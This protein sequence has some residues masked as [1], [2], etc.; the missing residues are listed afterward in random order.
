MGGWDEEAWTARLEEARCLRK[1]GDEGGFLRQALAA[2]NQRPQRAEPL[3]DL[4]RFYRE[5]GMNDASALFAEAGLAIPRPEQD[6]LFLEDFVYT[7]GLREE[8]SIAANYSRDPVRKDRGYAACNWL[9][10]NRRI[11][12]A[13]REL[14]RSNLFFYVQPANTMMP[15]FAARPV[16]FSPPDGYRASNPSVARWGEQ[17]VLLQRT[18]NYTLTEDGQYQTSSEVSVHTRNF[19][20]HLTDELDIQSAAEIFPPA[21]M[22]EPSYNL[23][24]GFEDLRLFAWR[25]DLWGCA[26]VRE[27][28]PEGWCEQVI[29]RIDARGP[30][31]CRLTDWRVL[32]P[33]GPRL[34]EKNWMPRV[35]GDRLQFICRCDPTQVLDDHA[36][37]T[38]EIAPAIAAERFSGGSQ[39]IEFDR[40][41]LALVHEAM[42]RPPTKQRFYQ[43][44]FVWFDENNRLRCVSH[45]FFFH[46]K[47]VEFA[48]GLTWHPDGKR[49]LISFGVGDAEAWIATVDAAEVQG[50]LEDVER[51]PSA[52]S[53]PR[54]TPSPP[55]TSG[56]VT[57]NTGAQPVQPV[58]NLG[59]LGTESFIDQ[60][61]L[62]PARKLYSQINIPPRV[63][64]AILAKQKEKVLPLYLECI[65]SLDYPK[66]SIV[67][68]IRTNNNTD[69]TEEL[70]RE[71]IEPI[72]HLYAGVEFDSS[73]V[74]E[75]VQKYSVHEWN[76][77]RFRVLANIR[78]ISLS[79][80]LEHN[81]DFYFISDV[82]NFFHPCTLRELVA[83]NLPIVAP[84]LRSISANNYFS[85]LHAE[86]DENGYFSACDQYYWIMHRYVRGVFEVP[87]VHCTYAIRSDVIP[88]LSYIDQT[89][90]Y[91]YVVFSHLARA[92]G[93]PQYFDNRQVYGYITFEEGSDASIKYIGDPAHQIERART[94]IE[95]Q[96][97]RN[98]LFDETPR[99][100]NQNRAP[101]DPGKVLPA[102]L[103]KIQPQLPSLEARDN[104][105]HVDAAAVFAAYRTILGREP[106]SEKVVRLHIQHAN[107][108]EG[109][110]QT[111]LNSEEF[112]LR[113]SAGGQELQRSVLELL[114]Y[115]TP[116]KVVGYTKIRVGRAG[117]GGYVMVNDFAGVT[118]AISAGIE[119]DV[120]WDE[121]IAGRGID[122][123]QF[124]HTV[125]GPPAANN[126]F[127]FFRRRIA[128]DATADSENIKSCLAKIPISEGHLIIKFD[129][130]GAEWEVFDN[131][132]DDDLLRFSQIV[133]EFHGFSKVTDSDW[134][135]RAA[136]VLAKLRSIFE[137]VHVHGNNFSPLQVVANVPFPDVVEVTFVNRSMYQFKE[138]TEVFPTSI[139]RPNDERRADIFLGSMR[140][141]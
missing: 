49:L 128:S 99:F 111:F 16:G 81:C 122:V 86:I 45:P 57:T 58:P 78:N 130:E 110:L 109:L 53:K 105:T 41:W 132:A 14:A 75:P 21:D 124:D 18:V 46:K 32:H 108:L 125:D 13:S 43:H 33:E 136:R 74:E 137:V 24:L 131:A 26:S 139:D 5:K 67:L 84:M 22:P 113:S 69:R 27:L 123:Y 87:V 134:R 29:A 141:K 68:Y 80:T 48:A 116:R 10:L 59:S 135:E 9:A 85:N 97:W 64:I 12:R 89:G 51:L 50:V 38:S 66:S 104:Y 11:P 121:E 44:R 3:Y 88:L 2:F 55:T 63:L 114:S 119:Y 8:Y 118:V 95:K 107:N 40:G 23:V 138:S 77:I 20:L 37:T 65:E 94:L 79:K 101:R 140:F 126:R 73:D 47:G 54:L 31:P 90:R 60:H 98:Y 129:I 106:E 76:P 93:V 117:D 19:L 30:G 120:S 133:V 115:F 28:T 6:I 61:V 34:D 83:L 52:I 103:A 82:D 1:L 39:V 7:T 35:E 25:G 42:E 17:I 71:W 100:I 70:L 92:A 127:H 4:A 56:D 91:E 72:R 15:S 96:F 36:R 112:R 62:R 102:T